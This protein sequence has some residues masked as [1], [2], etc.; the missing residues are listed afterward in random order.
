[1]WLLA[2]ALPGNARQHNAL[3]V[4]AP[5]ALAGVVARVQSIDPQIIGRALSSAGLNV[6]PAIHITL[7][8]GNEPWSRNTPP[9]VVGQAF[10][11]D[12]IVIFPQRV[13][14]Y[15]Y[16]S[17][18]SVVLHEIAHLALSA[19]TGGRPLPR[20]FHEGVAVS[21]E[22]G[23]GLS[24]QVRLLV[25]AQQDPA[26]D[27]VSRLFASDALPATTTAYLLSAALVEDLRRRHG[28]TLPG[29]IAGRVATGMAFEQAF[30][31]ATG[32]TPDQAAA[33]AWRVYRGIRWLPVLTGPSGVWAAILMLAGLAFIV[34]QHRRRRRR[35]QWDAEERAAERRAADGREVDTNANADLPEAQ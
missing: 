16:D 24:S 28:A 26:I 17:L 22:S 9:W 18:E 29:D 2:A 35:R 14:A 11:S 5:P 21:V 4:K 6:P 32:E 7:V 25:A 27:D 13:G 31:T 1:M 33:I 30:F 8:D 34:R 23:W 12:T 3:V 20:W 10:G 19:R 15:P